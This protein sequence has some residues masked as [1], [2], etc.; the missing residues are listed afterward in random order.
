M[1]DY[2]KIYLPQIEEF[3]EVNNNMNRKMIENFITMENN[4]VEIINYLKEKGV[5]NISNILI[6]RPD[7]FFKKKT[8]LEEE[9]SKIDEK[10]L[11][12]ILEK[13]IGELSSFNI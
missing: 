11:L 13:N 6:K 1:I 2:L 7:K 12:Y 3:A 4:V 8:R 9:F 5:K 10:L